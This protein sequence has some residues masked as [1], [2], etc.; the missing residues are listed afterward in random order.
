MHLAVYGTLR[1]E[2][3]NDRHLK[4]ANYKGTYRIRGWE[5]RTNRCF[6]YAIPNENKKIVVEVYE[7][8]F[9]TLNNIDTIE[10][11]PLHFTRELINIADISAWM[12]VPRYPSIVWAETSEIE[13]GDWCEQ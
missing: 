13:S 3:Y 7:I 12:Y 6:P 4:G 2:E 8:D 1:K 9:I 5:L 11:F 10:G